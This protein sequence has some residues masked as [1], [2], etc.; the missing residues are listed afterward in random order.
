MNTI[1]GNGRVFLGV[2]VLTL[3]VRVAAI[4][5]VH[6]E[7]RADSDAALLVGLARS[8]AD[9]K[10]FQLDQG[11]YWTGVPTLCRSP[12]WPLVVSAVLRGVAPAWDGQVALTVNIGFDALNAA[13]IVALTLALG[14]SRRVGLIAGA[15]YALNPVLVGVALAL[16]RD[17]MAYS[18]LLLFLLS[19]VH[20]CRGRLTVTGVLMGGFLIG[21]ACLIRSDWLMLVGFAGLGFIWVGRRTLM[22]TVVLTVLF[23]MTAGFVQLPWLVRNWIHY[24]RFPMFGAGGGET[25][26]GGNNEVSAEVGA[27]YWGYFV[28]PDHIPGEIPMSV[29]ART[30]TESEVDDYYREKAMRWIRANPRKMPGLVCGKIIRAYVPIPRTHGPAVLVGS[31]W[32]WL[33]YLF[34]GAGIALLWRRRSELDG[35][36][37]V[38]LIALALAQMGTIVIFCGYFRYVLGAELLL[39][40][41]A[42]WVVEGILRKQVF[43]K[44]GGS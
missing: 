10:G 39:C 33:G 1:I 32:R 17:S 4:P 35:R 19:M 21:Y 28:F 38:V 13:L 2:M 31:A 22:R 37:W 15:L 40:I 44:R 16:S 14:A 26:W 23:G 25:L 11:I 36:V 20:L 18:F 7:T 34:G 43:Y 24:D 5:V 29:L 27:R 12:G 6:Y 8:L 9:G 41:P 30:H 3:I 42:A